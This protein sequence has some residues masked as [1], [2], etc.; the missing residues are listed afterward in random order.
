[1]SRKPK[2]LAA[3]LAATK[4]T[5]AAFAGRLGVTQAAVSRWRRGRRVPSLAMA[6]RIARA[7]GIPVDS[8]LAVGR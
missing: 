3:Y 4:T 5:Q 8:L 2:T 7:T 6:V 1:M